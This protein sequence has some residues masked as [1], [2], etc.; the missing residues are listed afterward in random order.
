MAKKERIYQNRGANEHNLK[1]S[2]WIFQE[3]ICST[4]RTSGFRQIIAGI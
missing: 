4:D 3:R 1:I 2:M